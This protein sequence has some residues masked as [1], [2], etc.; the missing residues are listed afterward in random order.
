[1]LDLR[2]AG[3]T[4]DLDASVNYAEVYRCVC[5]ECTARPY[6]LIEA[7]AEAIASTLLKRFPPVQAVKVRVK[8]PQA[9]LPGHFDYVGVEIARERNG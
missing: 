5:A 3:Q 1:M 4:D 9:P 6:N 2:R 7:V 8:K